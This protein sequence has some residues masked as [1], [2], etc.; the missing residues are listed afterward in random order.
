MQ[1]FTIGELAKQG[2]VGIETVRY[3]ERR[4]LIEPEARTESG[5]RLYRETSADR[6]RFI[7]RAQSLGFTLGE[8]ADLLRI[9]DS[10]D[11][12]A[13]DV[14]QLTEHKIADIEQRIGDLRR[15]RD[16]LSEL[17]ACCP[18]EGSSEECPILNALKTQA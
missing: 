1:T 14:K 10:P 4:G 18:G 5:Y 6:L 2:G 11:A 7:R 13:A 15:M 12:G 16:A 3:Y 8:I 17:A 9:S